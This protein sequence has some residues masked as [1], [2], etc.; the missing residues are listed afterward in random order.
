MKRSFWCNTKTS[1]QYNNNKI[2]ENTIEWIN[3]IQHMRSLPLSS[4]WIECVKIWNKCRNW[5]FMVCNRFVTIDRWRG[6]GTFNSYVFS[7]YTNHISIYGTCIYGACTKCAPWLGVPTAIWMSAVWTPWVRIG[8]AVTAQWGI[9]GRHEDAV[10]TQ[11]GRIWSP[12]ERR[13]LL[14]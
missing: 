10:R 1:E 11:W 7:I 12:Q 5:Q 6:G 4:G 2:W 9:L 13:H 3:K 14:Q 8:N